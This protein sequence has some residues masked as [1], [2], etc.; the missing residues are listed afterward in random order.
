[1]RLGQLIKHH[2]RQSGYTQRQLAALVN[3]HHTTISHLEAD[4]I[5]VSNKLIEQITQQICGGEYTSEDLCIIGGIFDMA[6]VIK[7]ANSDPIICRLLRK[8]PTLPEHKIVAILEVMIAEE[9]E[10]II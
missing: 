4:R 5:T 3:V 9:K 10:E 2:R 7:L 8:L 6:A 1:M